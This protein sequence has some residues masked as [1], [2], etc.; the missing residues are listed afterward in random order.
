M[1]ET[2]FAGRV[3]WRELMATDVQRAVGFYGE[4]FGWTSSEMPM[5][6]MGVYTLMRSGSRDVAGIMAAPEGV[7]Y[8]TA[9]DVD[10]AAALVAQHGGTVMRP[11]FDLPNIGRAALVRDPAGA[12][13][14]LFRGEEPGSTDTDS[15]PPDWT[16]CWSQ[17]MTP[18]PAS[19][20]A[21]YQAIFPW[22]AAPMPGAAD[23]F[24]FTRGE[25]MIASA[26]DLPPQAAA[27][28]APPHWL[29]YVAVPDVDA[30]FARAQGLGAA[31]YMPPTDIP[32][33]GR[34]AVLGD[35]NGAVIALWTNAG[36]G[37]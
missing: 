36:A 27:M 14:A 33:M 18:E 6:D 15:R 12:G 37:E 32:G 28:G 4:L 31:A 26:M 8:I 1:S 11:P 30:S 23:T 9:D 25:K 17:L 19:A 7:P 34:F 5:G 21:F 16:F 22:T 24:L 10:A 2:S 20:V 3:V 29:D 13:F 35:P